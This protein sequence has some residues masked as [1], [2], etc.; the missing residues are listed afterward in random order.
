M[1]LIAV[2][3]FAGLSLSSPG[4]ADARGATRFAPVGNAAGRVVPPLAVP[5]AFRCFE[6]QR[7]QTLRPQLQGVV[8]RSG[9]PYDRLQPL[10]GLHGLSRIPSS[11]GHHLHPAAAGTAVGFLPGNLG[12]TLRGAGS[13][14][15]W[16]SSLHTALR[17]QE[18]KVDGGLAVIE[19]KKIPDRAVPILPP[20]AQN[21]RRFTTHCTSCQLCVSAC[22]NQVLR[23]SGAAVDA[24]EA[25]DVV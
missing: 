5:A 11:G 12:P 1:F 4:A 6:V 13:S 21:L 15:C 19:E 14:A 2:V 17:A 16:G 3:T 8:H 22:P 10:R 9:E 23:P 20:G 24:D 18:K 25:R 7:L